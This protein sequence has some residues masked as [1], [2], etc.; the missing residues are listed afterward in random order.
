MNRRTMLKSILAGLVACVAPWRRAKA[1]STK[2]E[3][4]RNVRAWSDYP[5]RVDSSTSR[6]ALALCPFRSGNIAHLNTRT[7]T[8]G[9][10]TPFGDTQK[11]IT[12]CVVMAD[13]APGEF[14]FVA[15]SGE[16]RVSA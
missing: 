15:I 3:T 13:A 14:V 2:P 5:V 10:W 9:R 4:M 6:A 11:H 1:N 8:V 12:A 16:V 7:G